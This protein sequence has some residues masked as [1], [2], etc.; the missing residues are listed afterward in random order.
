MEN[1]TTFDLETEELLE[2]WEAETKR[3]GFRVA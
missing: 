1:P 3:R 2:W